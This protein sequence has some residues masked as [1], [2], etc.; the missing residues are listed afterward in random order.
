MKKALN[1]TA[2]FISIGLLIIGISQILASCD[3][4]PIGYLQ[5]QHAKWVPDS[6]I[7]YVELDPTLDAIQLKDSIP[8]QS[9]PLSGVEGTLPINYTVY[10]IQSDNGYTKSSNYIQIVRNGIVNVDAYHSLPPGRYYVKPKVTN[11]G[12]THYPDATFIVIVKQKR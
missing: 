7:V 6:M 9:T 8:Y 1:I 2:P 3:T 4:P 12:Y 10:L 5:T 11:E